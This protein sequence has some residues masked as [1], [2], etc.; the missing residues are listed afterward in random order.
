MEKEVVVAVWG[1]ESAYGEYRG[2]N[3]IVQSLATLA[4][5]GRRG[6]FFEQQLIAALSSFQLPIWH[7]RWISTATGGVTSGLMIQRTRW[8]RPQPT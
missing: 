6:A 7:M 8:L 3:D 2:S 4:Y 1:L 5:E